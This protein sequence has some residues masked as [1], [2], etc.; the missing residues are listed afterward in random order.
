MGGWREE[1]ELEMASQNSQPLRAYPKCFLELSH[2]VFGFGEGSQA[3]VGQ[4]CVSRNLRRLATHSSVYRLS[5]ID[6]FYYWARRYRT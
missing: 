1:T 3:A 2:Q 4:A 5:Q 6:N